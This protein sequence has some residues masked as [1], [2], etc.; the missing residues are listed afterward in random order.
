M[1]AL[2]DNE[3]SGAGR[4]VAFLALGMWLGACSWAALKVASIAAP[5]P[6]PAQTNDG[7]QDQEWG[8]TLVPA[9][10]PKPAPRCP[11]KDGRA[12]I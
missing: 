5:S 11:N 8:W 10:Q 9:S 3:I 6:K 12:C 7:K 2:K 1:D 4:V